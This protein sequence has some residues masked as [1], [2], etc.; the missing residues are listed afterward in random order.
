MAWNPPCS[1][2]VSANVLCYSHRVPCGAHQGASRRVDG[3]HGGDQRTRGPQPSS[4]A[5]LIA[6]HVHQMSRARRGF[7]DRPPRR[8]KA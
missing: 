4:A 7:R 5:A 1:E 3:Q 8:G 2:R 6:G